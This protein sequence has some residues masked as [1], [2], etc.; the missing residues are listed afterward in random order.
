[1]GTLNRE[2]GG[3]ESQQLGH[4]RENRKVFYQ[5]NTTQTGAAQHTLVREW[6]ESELQNA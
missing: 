5:Q 3:W 1:M 4:Q 6:N 2:R